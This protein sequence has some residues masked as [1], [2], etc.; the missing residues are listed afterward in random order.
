MTVDQL[1]YN[2]F[3]H[4]VASIAM[5]LDDGCPHIHF[6]TAKCWDRSMD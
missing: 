4:S 5:Q 2:T 1:M 3:G 6:M